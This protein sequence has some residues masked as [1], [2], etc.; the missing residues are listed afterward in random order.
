MEEPKSYSIEKLNE[1]NYRSWSQVVE[2]HLDDQD[3]WEVVKGIEK[4]PERP[5]TPAIST[6]TAQTPEQ[7][8]AAEAATAAAMEEFETKLEA[9][10]K[11]AKKARKLIISTISPSVMTYVEGTKDP[12]EM[13]TILEGRYKPKTRVTLRQLQRQFNTIKMVDDDGDMEKHLQKVERLKRQIE[14]QGE[15]ISDSNY[16]SVLLNCA[17]P[18]YDVQISILEAQD[19]VTSTIIINRLLEEYRKFLINKP[20]KTMMALLTKGKGAYQKGGKSKSGRNSNPTKF[21]DK[22]NHCNK[23]GHKEDQCWN[24]HPELKPEKSRKDERMERPKYSLMATTTSVTTPKRQSGPH[25]WFTDSGASDHFSPHKELFST[26]S[27]LDEPV[28]IET[29]EGAAIGTGTGTIAL[30]VLGKDDI[31]TE[32]Q[33]NNVIYAPNMSSNL[34]SLM[35]AYDKGYEI[36]ITPGYGLRI[37]HGEALVATT[38]RVEGGLFRLKTTTDT[39]AMAAQTSEAINHELDIDIWHRRMGHLGEDYVRKL[40]RMVDGIRIKPRTTVG[41]CEPCLEGKQ[42]RQP[43][44][45]PA[46]R[47]SEPL[48]LI[49]SDLCGPIDP[50]SYG[51]TNYYLLFTDDFTRM[52]H[53][54]P[55]KRKSSAAVLEKFREYKPEVEKQTGKEIKR[56]RTDGGGEYEK[57]MGAHLK[58]SGIIHETT[59]PYSPDQNGVAERANRTIMERVKAI[60]AEAKLDKRL[61][62]EIAE[63]VVYLKNRSPT[64]AV[65]TTPYELW[66]GVKPNLSHLRIIGST[67]YVH[68]PKEKRIKLDTHSHKGILVGYGGTNQYKV[69]DLT[70]KDVVVSRDVVFIEGKPISQTPAILEEAPRIIHDSIT[71][72]PGPPPEIEEPQQMPTPPASEHPDSEDPEEEPEELV[73]PQILMQESR[74]TDKLQGPAIGPATGGTTSTQRASARSNKGILTSTKFA[75]ENF[76]KAPRVRMA[77]LARNIDPNDEDEPRT[78][79]EAI[80]H[81]TRGKQWEKAIRDEYNSLIKNHTWDLVRR[82][83]RRMIVTNKF[84]FKHKKNE[85]ARIVRLKARLVAR[86]FSQIY[87]ID[88]LDTYAPVVKLAS[89][90]ILLAIAAIYGLE[91]HQMDVVTAFL[92]GDLEEEIFMEQPE[93]FEIGSKEDDLV[94]RLRKSIYGLK[95]APRVWNQRIRRFL[96]SI[97]FDQTYSDPCVY[98]NSDTDVIIAMWVDDLIIFGKDMASINDLKAQLNEEYEMK[99]LGE[100]NYFLGIQ[101]HRDKE[102]KIIHINQPGYIRTILERYDMQNSK[103]ANIPLSSGARL[104][105]AI[106]TDTL[107]DQ[108]EYQS[109]VGSLMYAMLAT[110]PDLAQLIQQ[111][112]QFSQKPTKTH[113]KAAKQGLRY[114]N[115]T[116]DEGITYNGNLGIRLQ[117]WSDA[118]WGGEEGRESVSGFVFTMAGGTVTYS[119]KKQGSVALSSTESEYMAILHALKE[120]IWLLRFL[121]EIGYDISNQNVIYCDNQSAIALAHNPEHH[122]RTKHIDIQYHFVRN[123]VEDGITRLEYCP[124]EDMVADGLT[125]A[126]GPERH[127]K[128]MRMMGM[129]V[130]QKSEEILQKNEYYA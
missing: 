14:E 92:A 90:R 6:S 3:L 107:V 94:C 100:L 58:G 38:V 13:W 12:A 54:Y 16:V 48:E 9:W 19:D 32:L 50:T 10:T 28:S 88:Y 122:A 27:K 7:T 126:L 74:T 87:G 93:G 104:I 52:T 105:K 75:D 61:W 65:A 21:D 23:R 55:L 85:I 70:R 43:S 112:S 81:P 56:L 130:W 57:W 120:Q 20:E 42:T 53:I 103:P 26:F 106:I 17:P 31:E 98:I 60:I 40:A 73:D 124:T 80:N 37:F 114:L 111:I 34:F 102:R 119:S 63:T 72:L 24:K 11:K 41:V 69:W 49:H 95:Q 117:C 4:K 35:A 33:L 128:L 51:G 67:A 118:N 121:K 44:R 76:D 62:M 96:K 115:G 82:P 22:C 29:A 77:K 47:A 78:V 39:F 129:S 127:R 123:C 2:S 64:S 46:T 68:I 99:D 25:I 45:R 36:R 101:V 83:P 79:Q 8:A 91:I 113:E 97:G 109:I 66:H 116:I 108:K 89:I 1:S 125:K 59:A 71:V 30:T 86:G 84:A 18:R 110:R 15:R 5:S